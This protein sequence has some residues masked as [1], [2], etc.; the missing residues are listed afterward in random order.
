VLQPGDTFGVY[1]I[2]E[3]LGRGTSGIVHKARDVQLNRVV[4]L[5]LPALASGAQISEQRARFLRE[6]RAVASLDG[7]VGATIVSV[8]QVAEINGQLN[9]AREFVEGRTFEQAV[10]NG[11]IRLRQGIRILVVVARTTDWVHQ[12]GLVHRNLHPS[13][14]LVAAD[15]TP[16]LIG[17]GRVGLLAGSPLAAPGMS[18]TPMSVDLQAV[19]LMLTWLCS[20]LNQPL[21]PSLEAIAHRCSATGA[22]AFASAAALADALDGFL[23][24]EPTE[25]G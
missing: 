25:T 9:Y 22:G 4:A 2:L 18:G 24:T 5:K 11:S 14:V 17:F 3:E 23:A 19:G 20:R 7:G 21:P 15:G 6:A 10:A 16:K 13:N 1:E 8:L 12:R